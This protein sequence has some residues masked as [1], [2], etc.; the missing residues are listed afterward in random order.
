M[1][2]SS[3]SFFPFLWPSSAIVDAGFLFAVGGRRTKA[4]GGGERDGCTTAKAELT[5]DSESLK[6]FGRRSVASSLYIGHTE[7]LYIGT[8]GVLTSYLYIGEGGR[9]ISKNIFSCPPEIR[10]YEVYVG[11]LLWYNY[12]GEVEPR[13]RRAPGKNKKAA[14]DL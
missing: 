7:A 13:R 12:N 9:G 2:A 1:K 8:G 11:R 14:Y 10:Q 4:L 3:K 6:V 5:T